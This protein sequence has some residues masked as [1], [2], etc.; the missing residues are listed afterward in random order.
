[1]RLD[2]QT[3]RDFPI[4]S[5][6]GQRPSARLP[7]L[8]GLQ[9]EAARGARGDGPVLRDE[10]R[11]RAPLDPHARRRGH[12]AVRGGAR[13]GPALHRR[14]EPRGG[15]L[16]PRD[17]RRPS[18]SWPRPWARRAPA[19]ATRSLVT[20]LEHHSN[21]DPVADGGPGPGRGAAGRARSPSDGL[22]DL[23][24][25]RPAAEPAHA[26]GG[27]HP[28]LERAR[29]DQSGRRD[30]RAGARGRRGDGRRW[31]SGGAAPSARYVRAR[32]RLLRL[33]GPQDARADG[34]RRPVRPARGAGAP[35]SPAAAAAR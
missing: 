2:E 21:I 10:P 9:P 8:G 14:A 31:R 6:D 23:E 18:T 7:G 1:M 24:R 11:Q 26:G 28:R 17:H 20:E 12:R 32:L 22:L 15:R 30:R 19:G 25:L 13:P 34:H 29:H 27:L 5:A 4:L 35:S 16:H 3:R 33:L